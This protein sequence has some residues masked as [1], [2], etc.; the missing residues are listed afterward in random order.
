[1]IENTRRDDFT[2]RVTWDAE[3]ETWSATAFYGDYEVVGYDPSESL[4]TLLS[5]VATDV[6]EGP[7]E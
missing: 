7:T 6:A 1:M 5:D 4:E 3:T 2:L